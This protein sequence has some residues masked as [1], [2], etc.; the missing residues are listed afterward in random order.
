M[1]R[2][3]V[4]GLGGTGLEVIRHLRKRVVEDYPEQGLSAF[5]HLAFLY[6]DTDPKETRVHD[7]N[8][9]RWQ[10]LGRSIHL[11]PNEYLIVQA[12]AVGRILENLE[13]YPQLRTWFPANQLEN[14][15][16]T[17][18]DTP[19]AQQIRALGR[20]IFTLQANDIRAQVA[21]VLD[22][23]PPDPEGGPPEI[24]LACSLSGGTGAGMFLDL[25]YSLR[26]WLADYG[27]TTAFLVLPDLTLEARRGRRYIANAYA[28]LMDLNYYSQ[29][30][31]LQGGKRVPIRFFLPAEG[32]FVEGNPFDFCYLLGT[33]NQAGLSLDL[34]VVP[35]LIAHRIYLSMDSAITADVAAAMNNGAMQRGVF[36]TDKVNGN[37]LAQH[38][39]TFGLATV[40]YPTEQIT[41]ILAYR[42][43]R[44]A[45]KGWLDAPPVDNVNQ[46][47]LARMPALLLSD[48]C[49]L[50]NR[51]L[52]GEAADYPPIASQISDAVATRITTAP[53][54]KREPYLN[55]LPGEILNDFRGGLQNYY[56]MLTD[57]LEGA[58]QVITRRVTDLVNDAL[59]DETLGYPF[60]KESVSEITGLLEVA[61]QKFDSIRKTLPGRVKGSQVSLTAAIGEVTE[62]EGA[63][64]FRQSKIAKAMS[65]VKT[66]LAMYL[67]AQAED[68]AYEYAMMLIERIL[69]RL[70]ML[71]DELAD[72][73]AAFRNL[74]AFIIREADR[75]VEALSDLQKGTGQFNGSILFQPGRIDS[76]YSAFNTAEAAAYL[77]QQVARR[78]GA[79]PMKADFEAAGRELFHYAVEWMTT[80]SSFR[81]AHRNVAHQIFEDFPG[82]I[83][84]ARSQLLANTFRRSQPFL[85]FDQGEIEIYKGEREHA[86]AQ[87]RTTSTSMV[88]LMD[89][90]QNRFPEVVRLRH[91]LAQSTGIAERDIKVITDTHQVV[92][93]SEVTAFPLRLIRDIRPMRD[94]Y[95]AHTRQSR[96]LPLHIQKEYLPDL[97]DL[98][99]VSQAEVRL[100]EQ[101]EE[102]F[103]AGWALDWIRPEFSDKEQQE[104]IRYHHIVSGTAVY[105]VLGLT[106]EE[107][108]QRISGESVS[109][110]LDALHEQVERHFAKIDN[111]LERTATASRLAGAV[112]AVRSAVAYG[113]ESEV[114]QRYNRIL[115]RLLRRFSLVREGEAATAVVSPTV[116]RNGT[117]EAAERT[118]AEKQFHE[119][120]SVI[121][122]RTKGQLSDRAQKMLLDRQTELQISKHRAQQI[123]QELAAQWR[124]R[125]PNE[126]ASYRKLV[127]DTLELTGG[128]PDEEAELDLANY[129]VRHGITAEESARI[130]AEVASEITR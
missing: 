90:D 68:R 58:A 89:H 25:A 87:D 102:D 9:K 81:V 56:R 73:E 30:S 17:A 50:G 116:S 26:R 99:L 59:T 22:A 126:L 100:K 63:L 11:T 122:A 60:A 16:V 4:I 57:N 127:Q 83:S 44:Q 80:R 43:V 66:A 105:D 91:E 103:L 8:R 55:R 23:M 110:V 19:G 34:N 37:Q 13:A 52:F 118:P 92:C 115:Q 94:A 109:A 101:A 130:R 3:I 21:G 47:I 15:D 24:I 108:L 74:Q 70:Q 86:Y 1:P 112:E 125:H 31:R 7:D 32:E 39:S 20:M 53:L 48:D 49:L 46:R 38:F 124:P 42:L 120:A 54:D 18:K 78:T 6:I 119:Y 121:L 27:T 62:S 113:E 67:T 5:P 82:E 84:D 111:R 129:E 65:K 106:R 107:A 77:K 12:P 61:R 40:Q 41:E 98:L 93:I 123:I 36:L 69:L 29:R 85:Q 128:E 104:E 35:D 14:L 72:W 51:D 88:A 75:R 28:A 76:V 79:L 2:R 10:V 45:V 95:R 114:F 96:A 97:G 117:D 33:R 64:M 71:R